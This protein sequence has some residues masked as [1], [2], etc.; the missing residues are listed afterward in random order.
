M[1]IPEIYGKFTNRDFFIFTAC[2]TLYFDEFAK[3]LINSIKKNT[4][5][6]LHIHVFNPRDD[7]IKYCEDRSFISFTYE[8]VPL[9]LFENA[10]SKWKV[11]PVDPEEKLKYDR[12]I[13]AAK[14]GKDPD[15]IHRIQKTYYACARFVRLSEMINH[16]Q[17]VFSIDIDAVVRKSIPTFSKDTALHIHRI[18]GPKSRFLAGGL[19]ISNIKGHDFLKKYSQ[20]LK[21]H[22][23]T[24]NIY[25]GLDQD[26]IENTIK[27][28]D[29][30]E[31][32]KSLID[33]EMNPNS[34]IWTAKGIRKELEIFISEQKKYNF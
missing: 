8:Y 3:P 20:E 27:G 24:D 32:P 22:I 30:T 6:N 16:T 4:D 19:C 31:L 15:I 12:I 28:F 23:E 11:V 25:W 33:W 7:Q 21:F 1:Q 17:T 5:T 18:H 9:T 29:Y 2:D 34:V 10:A 14:K 26:L 13:T